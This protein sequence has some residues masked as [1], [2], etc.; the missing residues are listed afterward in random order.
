M[1]NSKK[2]LSLIIII[3]SMLITGCNSGT[4]AQPVGTSFYSF[5][6]N[7]SGA[8]LQICR[9][10]S[11][12]AEEF[13]EQWFI[14]TIFNNT[15]EE[16]SATNSAGASNS[17]QIF[18]KDKNKILPENMNGSEIWN[19]KSFLAEANALDDGGLKIA[20]TQQGSMLFT[21]NYG[22]F[23][24]EKLELRIQFKGSQTNKVYSLERELV[25]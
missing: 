24:N 4:D 21:I 18:S 2:F 17:A 20:P 5:E 1:I 8:P 6:C 25:R 15:G 7:E 19:W 11:T 14:L 3:F 10:T 12:S 23:L 13:G 22:I 16:I 9:F